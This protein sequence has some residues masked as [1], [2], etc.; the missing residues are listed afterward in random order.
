MLSAHRIGRSRGNTIARLATGDDRLF[1]PRGIYS[2]HAKQAWASA[3]SDAP[4][5][6]RL[7][8]APSLSASAVVPDAAFTLA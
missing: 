4:K 6:N 7:L 5:F 8:N 2:F 3:V 1:R